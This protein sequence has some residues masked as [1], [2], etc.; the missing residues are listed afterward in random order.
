MT[1]TAKGLLERAGEEEDEYEL[2]PGVLKDL[3]RTKWY[4]WHGNVFQAL[5]ELQNLEMDLDAAAFETKDEN[6]QKLLN[7]YVE[8]NQA[9]VPNYGERYRNGRG[10][11][12]RRSI[13][14][15]ANGWP[16]ATPMGNGTTPF[17]NSTTAASGQESGNASQTWP[18]MTPGAK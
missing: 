5:N 6:A 17:G 3:E 1:Q 16:S 13:K 11:S 18:Q 4:L 10:S 8:R 15:S 2:R 14:W 9:S 12:S 7:T